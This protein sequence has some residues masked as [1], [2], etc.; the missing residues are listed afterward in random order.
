MTDKGLQGF[1]NNSVKLGADAS[2]AV[3]PMGKNVAA[4]TTMTPPAADMYTFGQTV[5]LYGGATLSGAMLYE[6]KE[7]NLMAYGNASN[8]RDVMMRAD[9]PLSE[10]DALR[11]AL[12][13]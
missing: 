6:N 10:A 12:D 3:G 4:G 2:L 7:W 13:R 8:P 9:G 5:G 1:L 11:S